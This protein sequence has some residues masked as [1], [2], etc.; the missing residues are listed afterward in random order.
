M[1]DLDKDIERLGD[2]SEDGVAHIPGYL[3]EEELE[4]IW[5]E[6]ASISWRDDHRMYENKRGLTIVQNYF[7]HSLKLDQ[8]D[9]AWREQMPATNGAIIKI[10]KFVQS[11]WDHYPSLID[12]RPTE[13]TFHRYDRSVG[14]SRHR[15]SKRFIGV[16]AIASLDGECDLGIHRKGRTTLYPTSPG[17]LIL[18]RAP[19]LFNT[20]ED[21]RPDHSV[22]NIRTRLR[23][24]MTLRQDSEPDKALPNSY[25]DNWRPENS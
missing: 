25:F 5:D 2:I 11:L 18:L 19:G 14:L 13:V 16:I 21:L 3:G 7:S 1:S 10:R 6:Q 20:D 4:H 8:G 15:D 9:Q 22:V 17:D 24:S 12:W 23:T